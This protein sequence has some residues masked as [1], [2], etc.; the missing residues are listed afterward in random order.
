MALSGSLTTNAYNGVRSLTLNWSATQNISANT[1]TINWTLIG[2]G[3]GTSWYMTG[4]TKVVIDGA[5]VHYSTNRIQ[6][7][8]GTVVASGSHTIGHNGDGTRSFSIR[9]EGAIYSYSVNCTAQQSF[10]L[11]QIPRK[12]TITGASNF[13][14]NENPTITISNPAKGAATVNAYI[15]KTGV[16]ASSNITIIY[17]GAIN[18]E[19]T[20][21]TF[22]LNDEQRKVLQGLNTTSNVTTVRFVLNTKIGNTY[23]DFDWRDVSLKIRNP[24]PTLNPTVVDSNSKTIALTGS[25]SKLVKYYS[26]AKVTFGANAVKGASLRRRKVTCGNKSLTADGTIN[27]VENG[28]FSFSVTDSRGNTTTKSITKTMVNY[29]KLSCNIGSSTPDASG[30][31]DLEVTGACYYGSFG[32]VDNTLT[33][34]YRYRVQ[35]T[36]TWGAWTAVDTVQPIGFTYLARAKVEGLDYQT[37]Y[38]FQARA[39]DKLATVTASAKTVKSLPTFDWSEKDFNFNVPVTVQGYSLLG[40]MK[41]LSTQYQL[42]ATVIKG[43]NYTSVTGYAQ[44]V[45]NSVRCNILATRTSNIEAGNIANETVCTFSIH[46]G[47]RIKNFDSTTF[48]TGASGGGG[49][50]QME[51]T[52]NSGTTITFKV[53]L[54]ATASAFSGFNAY[55]VIPVTLDFSKF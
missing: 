12:A 11:N 3:S 47:G 48:V 40:M 23:N 31:Y 44:L 29:V 2:S 26:N 25:N 9:I 13:Y 50:F 19:S 52:S 1:S 16:D 7:R 32:A 27:G 5:Q 37:A 53:T 41:A 49:F 20:S 22:V 43:T 4:P 55:F 24:N 34:Q 6:L 36:S 45:G 35:G 28:K 39:T 46:H 18:P 15:E 38:E 54:A 42:D 14:D 17:Y 33:V 51:E 10:T 8:N 21:V 30:S